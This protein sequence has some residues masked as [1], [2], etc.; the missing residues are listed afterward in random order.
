MSSRPPS[1]AARTA[2]TDPSESLAY[3]VEVCEAG[4]GG[5]GRRRER[6]RFRTRRRFARRRPA[7]RK[8]ARARERSASAERRGE[9]GAYHCELAVVRDD[10]RRAG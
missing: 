10:R 1:A 7:R 2:T 4:G 9:S 5:R 8:S 6:V 3:S